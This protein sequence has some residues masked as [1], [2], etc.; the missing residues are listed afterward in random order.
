M[1]TN[2]SDQTLFILAGAVFII[3]GIMIIIVSIRSMSASQVEE[4]LVKYIIERHE[5]PQKGFSIR[6]RDY[7]E[8]FLQRTLLPWFNSIISYF[9]RFTPAQTIEQV[10]RQLTMAGNP[11]GLR[12]QTFYG[13]RFVLLVLG[14]IALL[15]SGL[16]GIAGGLIF[17]KITKEPFNPLLGI[18]AVSC[19][20]TTAKVAQKCALSVNKKAM[21]L[22]F[23]MGPCVAGV[24]TT[25]IITGVYISG[26][27]F[28][29]G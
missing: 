22:P 1:F 26:L 17:R 21:I 4:R 14:V 9:G 27:K 16:G 5:K 29:G 23:A 12:A 18:A 7:S 24:I 6:G 8:S 3:F 11:L 25:A 10:N 13:I 15:L 2:P 20:P 28:L 19:V